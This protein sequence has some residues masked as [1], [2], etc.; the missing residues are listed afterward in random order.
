MQYLFAK[1]YAWAAYPLVD[2]YSGHDNSDP[3][4]LTR[5]CAK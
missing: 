5:H 3:T 4:L 1:A 2:N